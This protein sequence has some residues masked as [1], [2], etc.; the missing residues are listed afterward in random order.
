MKTLSLKQECYFGLDDV[1]TGMWK[2]LTSNVTVEEAYQV[3]L[4][5]Y[6]VEP[7]RLRSDLEE[8]V[9]QLLTSDLL[10]LAH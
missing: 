5:Q 9:Q 6:A 1:G 8:L 4:D 3:L 7:D 10:V 2:A